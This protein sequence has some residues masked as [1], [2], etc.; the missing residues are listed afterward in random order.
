[1][2][3]YIGKMSLAVPLTLVPATQIKQISQEPGIYYLLN[4]SKI[5]YIGYSKTN[6]QARIRAHVNAGRQ[7]SHVSWAIL[8]EQVSSSCLRSIERALIQYWRPPENKRFKIHLPQRV[9]ETPPLDFITI[10]NQQLNA[11]ILE[12]EKRVAALEQLEPIPHQVKPRKS[13]SKIEVS[14]S[15]LGFAYLGGI[16]LLNGEE[17]ILQCSPVHQSAN[18]DKHTEDVSISVATPSPKPYALPAIIPKPPEPTAKVLTFK[19]KIKAGLNAAWKQVFG[20]G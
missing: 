10:Q 18:S 6:M 5:T 7:F 20:K 12:L 11:R 8:D 2:L 15:S 1:M 3:Q 17:V 16:I 13:I 4:G 19:Q 9:V 14:P